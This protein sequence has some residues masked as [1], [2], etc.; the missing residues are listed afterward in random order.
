MPAT[1]AVDTR[2]MRIVAGIST[3]DHPSLADFA[4]APSPAQAFLSF[5]CSSASR[6]ASGRPACFSAYVPRPCHLRVYPDENPGFSRYNEIFSGRCTKNN[7]MR[8][9][10][11][12]LRKQIRLFICSNECHVFKIGHPEAFLRQT[13]Q[14]T[15]PA[16]FW[17][18]GRA[19]FFLIVSVRFQTFDGQSTRNPVAPAPIAPAATPPIAQEVERHGKPYIAERH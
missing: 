8:R 3:Q 11:L 18:G 7:M 1:S 16:W 5:L 13:S 4:L 17:R 9:N 15:G 12:P 19:Q 6:L 14:L 2:S 10:N